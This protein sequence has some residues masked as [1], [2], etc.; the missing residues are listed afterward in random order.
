MFFPVEFIETTAERS[1][2][3]HTHAVL[4]YRGDRVIAQAFGIF[5]SWENTFMK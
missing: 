2:P 3:E 5:S 1:Y 4:M